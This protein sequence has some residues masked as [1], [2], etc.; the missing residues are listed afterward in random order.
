[1]II[2]SLLEKCRH[3]NTPQST[4]RSGPRIRIEPHHVPDANA[5]HGLRVVKKKDSDQ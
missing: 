4:M 3:A 1:L 2:E 5:L